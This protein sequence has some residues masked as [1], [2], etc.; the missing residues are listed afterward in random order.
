MI[1]ERVQ[2]VQSPNAITNRYSIA[3]TVT[4]SMRGGC[5]WRFTMRRSD[6]EPGMFTHNNTCTGGTAEVQF[7]IYVAEIVANWADGAIESDHVAVVVFELRGM[8]VLFFILV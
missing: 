5:I 2:K 8:C 4:V 6:R 1:E 3:V 7:P